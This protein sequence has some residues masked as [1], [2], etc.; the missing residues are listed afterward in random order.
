MTSR[1]AP[2]KYKTA[3]SEPEAD[4]DNPTTPRKLPG[5]LSES[6]LNYLSNHLNEPTPSPLTH[7]I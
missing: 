2:P 5:M 6:P 7:P 4:P 3:A 1:E